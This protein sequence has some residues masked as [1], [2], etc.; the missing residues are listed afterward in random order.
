M[1]YLLLHFRVGNDWEVF[2]AAHYYFY[3]D[4]IGTKWLLEQMFQDCLNGALLP[5]F[6]L[7]AY[8]EIKYGL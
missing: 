7:A 2:E 6:V 1:G 4:S 5:P 3:R 8:H